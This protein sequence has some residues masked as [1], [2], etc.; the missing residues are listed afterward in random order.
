MNKLVNGVVKC[1]ADIFVIPNMASLA[2]DRLF[3]SEKIVETFRNLAEMNQ[4]QYDPDNDKLVQLWYTSEDDLATSNLKDH[5][6][7]VENEDGTLY[8]I[9]LAND[10]GRLPESFFRGKTEGETI[11]IKIPAW[12]YTRSSDKR[13][14]IILDMTLTLNQ[15]D[16]RYSNFGN[17]EDVVKYV[18][19][20]ARV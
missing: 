7:H 17:F 1:N 5:G 19:I 13:M 9:K 16:Y 18:C 14:D 20:E 12:A 4:L 8:T 10:L 2:K 15:H 6:G 11:N 3:N